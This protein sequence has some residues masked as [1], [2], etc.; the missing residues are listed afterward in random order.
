M[1]VPDLTIIYYTVNA[2]PEHFAKR[3]RE[4][5]RSVSNNVPIISFSRLEMDFGQNNI[6]D[7][8]P[9]HINI[10]RTILRGAKM[11]RTKYVALCE[12][13]TFYSPEHFKYR[14]SKP[15]TFAYNI[16][17]WGIFTWSQPPIFSYKGRR[18]LSGMICEREILIL[19]L[20]ERFRVWPEE[21]KTPIQVWA[22]PGKYED[23]L[24]VTIRQTE[25]F[26][27]NPPN[28][29]FSHENGL[30]FHTIGKRKRLGELR[31]IEIPYWGRADKMTQLYV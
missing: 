1:S 17:C 14:P 19:A 29:M 23:Q 12:D 28:V 13:D 20:E 4:N 16:A 25:E 21:K 8:S 22:E 9:S 27:T 7:E 26:Y 31:A 3:V 18:N 24:G 15:E 30:S 11:A 5:I 6:V 10:Y 2:I